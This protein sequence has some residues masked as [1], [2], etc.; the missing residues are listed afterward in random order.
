MITSSSNFFFDL[1]WHSPQGSSCLVSPEVC[2]LMLTGLG[3]LWL[4]SQLLHT[5]VEHWCTWP[6]AGVP[7]SWWDI[8]W[9]NWLEFRPHQLALT[10]TLGFRL[11]HKG[12]GPRGTLPMVSDFIWTLLR[13]MFI[14]LHIEHRAIV[15]IRLKINPFKVKIEK[16]RRSTKL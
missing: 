10:E 12:K 16:S 3:K 7:H 1:E 13:R 11:G 5:E 15:L 8:S 6:T 2:A 9:G 14:L 4:C